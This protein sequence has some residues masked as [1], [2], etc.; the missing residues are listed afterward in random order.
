MCV[1]VSRYAKQISFSFN[2]ALETCNTASYRINLYC[3]VHRIRNSFMK[4]YIFAFINFTP[5]RNN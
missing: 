2:L 1:V 5:F 3:T 4:K